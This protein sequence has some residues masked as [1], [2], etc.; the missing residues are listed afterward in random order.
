MTLSA[1]PHEL[2]LKIVH[3]LT[4]G[5]D[6]DDDNSKVAMVRNLSTT[7]RS[8]NFTCGHIIFRSYH[9]DIRDSL[10]REMHT[11]HPCGTYIYTWN[12]S[13]IKARLAHLQSKAPFVREIFIADDGDGYQSSAPQNETRPFPPAFI[14]ELL[15]TLRM[16]G[17]LYTVY[18]VTHDRW[19]LPNVM[20]STE[21]WSWVVE[22]SPTKLFVVGHFEFPLGE[23][24]QPIENLD[25]LGH[26]LCTNGTMKA[27]LDV[28]PITH[29]EFGLVDDHLTV[30]ETPRD[31]FCSYLL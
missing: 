30:T 14:P 28:S 10:S 6:D 20:I 26:I 29:F 3:H 4:D 9:L 18:I 13:M 15:S 19:D 2:R 24:L 5:C 16:L 27:L 31:L 11:R 25:I 17:P 23:V 1:L 8:L 7:C 22:V 12:H 21:L